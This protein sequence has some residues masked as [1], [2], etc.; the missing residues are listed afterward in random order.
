[1]KHRVTLTVTSLVSILLFSLHWADEI[2]RGIEPGT[3]SSYGGFVILFVWLY[4]TLA[5]IDRRWGLGLV[6]VGALLASVVPVLH[7]QG[8]GLVGGRIPPNSDGAFFWVW[9]NIALGASGMVSLALTGH[10]FVDLWRGNAAQRGA[11]RV[12]P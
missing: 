10:A 6:L 9:T 5:V 11:L 7:M 3:I 8:I 2:A 12:H 4:A 1:M